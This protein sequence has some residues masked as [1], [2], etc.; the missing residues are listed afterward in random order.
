MK[1]L[2][3]KYNAK[4][5]LLFLFFLFSC[6][7]TKNNDFPDRKH[8]N[9]EKIITINQLSTNNYDS[10]LNR[11]RK[12]GDRD[13][14]NEVFYSLMETTK[15]EGTDSIM[16]LS[17]IM[18]E[19]YQYEIAYFNYFTALCRKNNIEVNYDNYSSIDISKLDNS[20]K[21]QAQDWLK[22]MIQNK[23]ITKQQY[24]SIKK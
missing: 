18:A 15:E 24:D 16:S 12:N 9:P 21:T 5:I 14:Y 4:L 2:K 19:K 13:I 20:T 10:L 22:K 6:K 3:I 23:L 1:R 7:K 11:I 8:Q 17:K